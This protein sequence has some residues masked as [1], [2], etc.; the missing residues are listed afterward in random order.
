MAGSPLD[1][2]E[3]SELRFTRL[4]NENRGVPVDSSLLSKF[5]ILAGQREAEILAET[6]RLTGGWLFSPN[7]QDA[8]R[9][10]LALRGCAIPDLKAG[11][12]RK[13]LQRD[14]LHLEARGF[15]ELRAELAH[16]AKWK[17]LLRN[18]DPDTSCIFHSLRHGGA[19]TGRMTS[20]EPNLQNLHRAEGDTLA[21]TRAIMSGDAAKVAA[22]GPILKTLAECE[23]ALIAA[24]PGNRFLIVDFSSIEY[25]EIAFLAGDDRVLTAFNV[26]DRTG[27][28]DPYLEFGVECVGDIPIARDVGKGII[29]GCIF[30]SGAERLRNELL[31]RIPELDPDADFERFVKLFRDRHFLICRFWKK[32]QRAALTA[33]RRP[34][35][36]IDC[37]VLTFLYHNEFLKMRLPSGR[38]ISYPFA[39]IH[40]REGGEEVL[41]FKDAKGDKFVDCMSAGKLGFWGGA[42]A[43]N[44]TQGTAR[45]VMMNAALRL[46]AA[47]YPV[48]WTVHDEIICEVPESFGA[49]DE[50]KRIAEQRPAWQPGVPVAGKARS[51]PRLADIDLPVETWVA[52]SWDDVPLY[53]N[54]SLPSP[55]ETKTTPS[56]KLA[57][58]EATPL[59]AGLAMVEDSFADI[60]AWAVEREA[61]RKRREATAPVS[62]HPEPPVVAP[63]SD[64]P[65]ITPPPGELLAWLT[66]TAEAEAEAAN[67]A[68]EA[69][70]SRAA[71]GSTIPAWLLE[72][73]RAKRKAKQAPKIEAKAET[74]LP[75]PPPPPPPPENEYPAYKTGRRQKE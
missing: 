34:G 65:I 60:I 14:D 44:A 7:Q 18:I 56:R 39:K 9:E 23:R 28:G 10:W 69:A 75:P 51:G 74:R 63:E 30:G 42:L 4:L 32:I 16:S 6:E 31:K 66:L 67:E 33:I 15:L 29:L 47:S 19:G 48:I 43:E 50:F 70:A 36:E 45:D 61:A 46:E 27:Q 8:G 71:A 62:I 54:P 5:K 52:G 3:H 40:V 21:K 55:Q 38:Y 57:R 1:E 35:Q 13:F 24:R 26:F 64:T 58:P 68:A 49:L 25:R 12:V 11:T 73:E 17:G 22:F 72:R 37:N 53:P 20:R 41:L 2:P 59:P